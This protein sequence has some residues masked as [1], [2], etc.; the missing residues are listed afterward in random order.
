MIRPCVG[1]SR[2]TAS[3]GFRRRTDGWGDVSLLRG[4]NTR[5]Y[6]YVFFILF[7]FNT[8]HVKDSFAFMKVFFSF[9][10][11]PQYVDTVSYDYLIK[12]FEKVKTLKYNYFIK[13]H[14]LPK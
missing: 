9:K 12:K 11:S 1:V 5:S 14:H 13:K 7:S 4:F 3:F 10:K 6:R 8:I 2:G